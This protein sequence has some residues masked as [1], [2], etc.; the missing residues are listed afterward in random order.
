MA[1]L[2]AEYPSTLTSMNDLALVYDSHGKWDEAAKLLSHVLQT[3][4]QKLGAEHPDT[5]I[6]MHNLARVYYNQGRLQ[7]AAQLHAQILDVWM[8]RYGSDHPDMREASQRYHEITAELEE[9]T[10]AETQSTTPHDSTSD[11]LPHNTSD[12]EPSWFCGIASVVFFFSPAGVSKDLLIH[13][14]LVCFLYLLHHL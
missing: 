11:I 7:D 1:I 2:G 9:V 8:E 4:K 14:F 5:L 6:S 10:L 3:Q 12:T 13:F